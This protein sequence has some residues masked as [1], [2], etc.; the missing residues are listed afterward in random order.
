[1]DFE[2]LYDEL[3]DPLT[4]RLERLVGDARTAED[5]RQEAFARAWKS[6]PRDAGHG[7][8]RAWLH[9]TAHNLAVDELRRRRTRDWVPYEEELVPAFEDADPDERIAAREALARLSAHER[10]LLLMR[11]EGGLSHAEIGKLLEIGEEAARKR[12]AR[13]RA[14]LAAA[15]REVT[16]RERPLVLVLLGDDRAAP[17]EEWIRGAGG[18][19][20]ILDGLRF[21]RQLAS[22]DA[23][24]ITGSNNDVHP[25]LYG[26]PV[27][28]S[29]GE[30]DLERDRRDLRALRAALLQDVPLVGV[31]R[32]HQLLNIAMGGTLHQDIAVGRRTRSLCHEQTEHTIGT[33]SRTLARRVLGRSSTVASGH[34]Q[35]VRRVGR[36]LR[37]TSAS[38]DGVVETLEL[39]RHRF[40]IG[41]QWHPEQQD[42]A[43]AGDRLA[44]AL[45][46]AAR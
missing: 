40:A 14:A 19:P 32:G 29:L 22:A 27:R 17:Y 20:R 6:G 8:M 33:G 18:E 30:L 44:S 5:L 46:E 36:G 1:M 13:A 21:E 7:H 34:H 15:H 37:V 9:R 43:S 16:P 12:V 42:G 11:F 25:G 26:E 41:V 4:R 31:C 28:G 24:V 35:A 39:P 45:V 3:R 23:L 2:S 10:F 38:P